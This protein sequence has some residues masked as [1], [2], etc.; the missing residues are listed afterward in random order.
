MNPTAQQTSQAALFHAHPAVWSVFP[1]LVV[2]VVI[3]VVILVRWQMSRKAW[4]FHP[5]GSS[6]FLHD[7][8]IRYASI[9]L[10]FALLMVCVRYYIYRFHPELTA[11][12]YL[13][14]LYMSVFVFRRLARLLPHVKEIGARLDGARAQAK[15]SAKEVRT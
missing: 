3:S 2:V 1:L 12:P 10:P 6:G 14:A 15:L 8:V 7:E 9:W 13:Y 11:S 4:A 5:G